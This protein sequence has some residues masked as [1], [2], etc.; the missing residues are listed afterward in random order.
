[1]KMLGVKLIIN[2]D[3]HELL[4]AKWNFAIKRYWIY[5][6]KLCVKYTDLLICDSMN[7]KKYIQNEF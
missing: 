4:R 1:M 5:S 3:G 7:I 2:P 6:E